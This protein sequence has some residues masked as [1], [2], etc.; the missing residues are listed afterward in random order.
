MILKAMSDIWKGTMTLWQ[1]NPFVDVIT[2]YFALM[3]DL[4]ESK[5][6]VFSAWGKKPHL[7]LE[8]NKCVSLGWTGA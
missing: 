5:A 8:L 1:L 4:C 2:W 3:L 7:R 6:R